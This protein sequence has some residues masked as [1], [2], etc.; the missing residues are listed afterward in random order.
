MILLSCS[1]FSPV[2]S[3]CFFFLFPVVNFSSSFKCISLNHITYLLFLSF[4]NDRMLAVLYY[5]VQ[6][7]I[8]KLKK[9]S[10]NWSRFF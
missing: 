4:R 3:F 7:N 2:F 8:N 5:M 6:L 10:H 9:D 1:S